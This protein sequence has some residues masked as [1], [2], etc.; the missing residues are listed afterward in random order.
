MPLKRAAYRHQSA[1]LLV[2]KG[3]LQKVFLFCNL[4]HIASLG[5]AIFMCQLCTGLSVPSCVYV[6]Y[7]IS[8]CVYL[9][10]SLEESEYCSKISCSLDKSCF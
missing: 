2:I 9:D 3:T 5:P 8:G 7:S 6:V 4:L 10:T 1:V